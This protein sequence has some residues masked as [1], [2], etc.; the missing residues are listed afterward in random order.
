MCLAIPG[1]L[2]RWLCTDPLTAQAEVMFGGVSRVCYLACCPE[3][4][5]GAY[6]LVH[7]GVAIATLDTASAERLLAQLSALELDEDEAHGDAL[8]P[9]VGLT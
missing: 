8:G 7:A 1:K 5:V 4:E 6:V 9:G 2:T 3:A